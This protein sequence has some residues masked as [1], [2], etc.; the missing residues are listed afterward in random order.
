M[1][2]RTEEQNL[3]Y[4]EEDEKGKYR[5]LGL[6]NR[7]QAFNPET[8]PNL[9]YPLYVN[10]SNGCVKVDPIVQTINCLI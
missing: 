5:L 1:I 6:K 3:Q 8:R 4:P 2:E 7:N 9:Y 10:R